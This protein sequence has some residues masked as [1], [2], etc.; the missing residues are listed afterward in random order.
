[1]TGMSIKIKSLHDHRV[2]KFEK[3]IRRYLKKKSQVNFVLEETGQVIETHFFHA[4][5]FKSMV[6]RM[7]SHT[8]EKS[9]PFHKILMYAQIH[10]LRD[11]KTD[12]FESPYSDEYDLYLDMVKNYDIITIS[13]YDEKFL[14]RPDSPYWDVFCAVNEKRKA[15]IPLKFSKD[16]SKLYPN[17]FHEGELV[18]LNKS[19]SDINFDLLERVKLAMS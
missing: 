1:M 15:I 11:L 12:S 17:W 19:D 14:R 5:V 2:K 9:F 10:T 16:L 7:Y 13:V 3:K 18:A 8:E 6:E 4:Y